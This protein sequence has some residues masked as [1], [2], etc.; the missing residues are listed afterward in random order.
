MRKFH[1]I[2]VFI[3]VVDCMGFA[4]AARKLNMS[5]PAVTRA[6]DDLETQLGLRLLTRILSYQVA[7]HLRTGQPK[8]VL[9]R[10]KP[11]PLPVHV[12]HRE[13]RQTPQRVR[14]FLDMAIE[15]LRQEPTLN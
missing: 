14:A 10:F 8:T 11:P 12:V 13:G 9:A 3:A 6:I 5:T 1:L 2:N 7:A 4:G 15:Q